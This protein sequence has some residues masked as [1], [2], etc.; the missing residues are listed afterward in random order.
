MKKQRSGVLT[1]VA[2]GRVA[3]PDANRIM[4]KRIGTHYSQKSN[5]YFS[6][7][8]YYFSST[9]MLKR[10]GTHSQKYFLYC[11]DGAMN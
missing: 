11:L 2:A 10:I 5:Y 9:I 3:T 8:D 1:L 7:T 6:S 4:L